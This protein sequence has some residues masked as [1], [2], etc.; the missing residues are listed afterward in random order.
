MRK[1]NFKRK[2]N[3]DNVQDFVSTCYQD[4]V[5]YCYV[6]DKSP[7]KVNYRDTAHDIITRLYKEYG[8]RGSTSFYYYFLAVKSYQTSSWSRYGRSYTPET[9]EL[10]FEEALGIIHHVYTDEVY[11]IKDK[12]NEFMELYPDLYR[13]VERVTSYGG[14]REELISDY[15]KRP[16]GEMASKTYWNKKIL[17]QVRKILQK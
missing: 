6:K 9:E 13:L 3:Y 4:I 15:L 12:F 16:V 8:H 14:N 2:I 5:T 7:G 10:T 17:P 11:P 1:I